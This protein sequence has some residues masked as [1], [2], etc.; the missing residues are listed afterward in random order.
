MSPNLAADNSTWRSPPS[1]YGSGIQHKVGASGSGSLRKLQSVGQGCVLSEGLN[2]RS[3]CVSRLRPSR[4]SVPDWL[5]VGGLLP[6]FVTGASPPGFIRANMWEEP[7]VERDMET[8]TEKERG[9]ERKRDVQ[10]ERGQAR[11][12]PV[13]CNP[14]GSDIPSLLPYSNRYK[15][16]TGTSP[17]LKGEEYK[18]HDYQEVG[19]LESITR[20]PTTDMELKLIL[21][22]SLTLTESAI[23]C[24]NSPLHKICIIILQDPFQLQPMV[25][26]GPEWNRKHSWKPC[27]ISSGS[28]SSPA[29]RK[30]SSLPT[31]VDTSL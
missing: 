6:C 21:C 19:S 4:A 10:W 26:G 23:L 28:T 2:S 27:F 9:G 16:V 8:E 25:L 29:E 1:F 15:Q 24:L 14:H 20:L 11:W 18:G 31:S 13:F 22:C 7:E 17:H 12:Q 5:L 30:S 3:H